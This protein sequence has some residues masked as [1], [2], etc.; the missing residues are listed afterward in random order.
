MEETVCLTDIFLLQK[1]VEC[2]IQFVGRQL[3]AAH[4]VERLRFVFRR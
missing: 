3:D 2:G 4:F 1:I